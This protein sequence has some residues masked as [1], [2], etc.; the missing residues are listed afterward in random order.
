MKFR[1]SVKLMVEGDA[2]GGQEANR[3]R[4]AVG[5]WRIRI[6]AEIADGQRFEGIIE[7]FFRS[8]VNRLF[9]SVPINPA[10]AINAESPFSQVPPFSNPRTSPHALKGIN[11]IWKVVD[12][13][14]DQGKT[15]TKTIVWRIHLLCLKRRVYDEG[16]RRPLVAAHARRPFGN[17]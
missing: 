6:C 17:R 12:S 3:E 1:I 13:L 8:I 9:C 4:M 11:K 16:V 15:E 5:G 14:A 2:G 7:Y 10:D